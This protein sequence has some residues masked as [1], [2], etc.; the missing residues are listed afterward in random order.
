MFGDELRNEGS[1]LGFGVQP[2]GNARKWKDERGQREVDEMK[3]VRSEGRERGGEEA[4]GGREK[5]G[6][7][8]REEKGGGS[9]KRGRAEG[10]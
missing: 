7:S 10:R 4:K 8:E 5:E 3:D 9:S 1:G 2:L 6:A